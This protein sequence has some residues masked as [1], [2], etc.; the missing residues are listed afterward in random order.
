VLCGSVPESELSR[1][2][3]D[4]ILHTTSDLLTVLEPQ[5]NETKKTATPG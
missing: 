4:L 3:A 2:G 5:E 1:A